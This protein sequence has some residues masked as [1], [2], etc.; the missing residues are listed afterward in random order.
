MYSYIQAV[1]T[2]AKVKQLTKPVVQVTPQ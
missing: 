1:K 2:K